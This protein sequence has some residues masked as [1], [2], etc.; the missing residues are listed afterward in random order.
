LRQAEA[1]LDAAE[2]NLRL[3]ASGARPGQIATAESQAREA[4]AALNLARA[5]LG[6]TAVRQ[7]EARAAHAQV[8]QAEAALASAAASLRKFTIR[9][10]VPGHVDNTHVRAGEVVRQGSSILTL[11]DFSDT[12]LT[13]Y[14]PE[15]QLARLRLGDR[16]EVTVDGRPG[17]P[18]HGTVRR[19]ADQAEFTPKFVQ[20]HEERARTVFAVEI[21][22]SNTAGLLKPGMP[23]D[24]VIS[25]AA[26]SSAGTR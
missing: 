12:W 2:A 19:I 17:Q 15:P 5:N 6:Q 14:V 21:A 16:A 24:A 4:Q 25:V 26:P 22:I 8:A 9:A 3:L 20:T 11:V 18:L 1:T 13:V 10:S 7:A 23:A